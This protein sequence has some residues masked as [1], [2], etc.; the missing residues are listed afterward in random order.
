MATYVV[1]AT[2][3]DQGVKNGPRQQFGADWVVLAR[4]LGHADNSRCS[5]WVALKAPRRASP[6]ARYLFTLG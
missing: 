1:L 5:F 6:R 3:T 4:P 2:F